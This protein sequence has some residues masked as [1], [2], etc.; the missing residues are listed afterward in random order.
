M[1]NNYRIETSGMLA[2]ITPLA[3]FTVFF[4]RE[5]AEDLDRLENEGWKVEGAVW[6]KYGCW[7]AN[8]VRKN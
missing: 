1:K 5:I 7:N 2:V 3:D 6:E 8:M 4:T